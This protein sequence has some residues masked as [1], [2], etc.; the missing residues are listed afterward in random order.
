MRTWLLASAHALWLIFLQMLYL[1][2]N[3]IVPVEEDL[4]E[5]LTKIETHLFVRDKDQND[6]IFINTAYSAATTPVVDG[7]SPGKISIT[8][9]ERLAEFFDCLT[10]HNNEHQYL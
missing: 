5:I 7:T 8:D 1:N 4:V 6:I 10:A 9:R 2:S 3:W